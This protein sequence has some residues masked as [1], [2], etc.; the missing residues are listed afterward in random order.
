MADASGEQGL[1]AAMARR[2]ASLGRR[3]A[4]LDGPCRDPAYRDARSTIPG[5][6]KAIRDAG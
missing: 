4:K 6:S 3:L 2:A 5:I 1:A